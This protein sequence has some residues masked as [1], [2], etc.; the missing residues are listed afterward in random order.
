MQFRLAFAACAFVALASAC[1]SNGG[2]V[3]PNNPLN[4]TAQPT[5]IVVPTATPTATPMATPTPAPG[6]TA[7]PTAPPV[8]TCA[9]PPPDP[10]TGAVTLT[11]AVQTIAVPCFGTFTSTATVSANQSAG[12]TIALGASTDKTQGA[13]PNSNGN[14]GTPILYTSL[15]PNR[16]ISFNSATATIPTVV[17]SS[18]IGAPHTYAVQSYVP[19]LGGPNATITKLVPTGHSVRFALPTVGGGFPAIQVIV[20]LYQ[21]T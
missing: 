4:P 3:T 7:T 8:V 17:T 21:T 16:A 1:D 19:A 2:T 18:T 6:P 20:I 13:V 14:Y 11:G 10:N 15:Q 9:A 5:A 12:A